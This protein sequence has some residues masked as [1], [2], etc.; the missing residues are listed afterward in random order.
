MKEHA[1]KQIVSAMMP[2]YGTGRM[3]EQRKVREKREA[4]I[5]E[6]KQKLSD[7]REAIEEDTKRALKQSELWVQHL[8]ASRLKKEES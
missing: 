7:M 6:L 3:D 2:R 1:K 8:E 4:S 5:Q